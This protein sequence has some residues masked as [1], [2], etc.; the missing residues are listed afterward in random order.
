MQNQI[1]N[2]CVTHIISYSCN[3]TKIISDIYYCF[4]LISISALTDDKANV[5]GEGVTCIKGL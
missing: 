1:K 2:C 5:S 3:K 4:S